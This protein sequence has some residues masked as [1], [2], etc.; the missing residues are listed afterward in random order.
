MPRP[1]GSPPPA[2]AATY[3]IADASGE[4]Y[5]DG[6]P[7]LCPTEYTDDNPLTG[8]PTLA[9]KTA[10]SWS[11]ST[12]PPEYIWGFKVTILGKDAESEE[13]SPV[14]N[15][16]GVLLRTYTMGMDGGVQY[17]GLSGSYTLTF[18]NMVD[19]DGNAAVPDLSAGTSV[20]S[21][22]KIQVS[23]INVDGVE[24]SIK[25]SAELTNT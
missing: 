4:V 21:K 20:I 13:W 16:N 23:V 2:A 1:P 15:G 3:Q 6:N 24:S 8:V 17:P 18:A 14:K 25:E 22:W 11:Y 12:T 9:A 5:G 10:A 19:E 7:R